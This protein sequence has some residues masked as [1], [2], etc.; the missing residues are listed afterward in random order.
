MS[1]SDDDLKR[2]KEDHDCKDREGKKGCAIC[3]LLARLEASE[4]LNEGFLANLATIKLD[5]LL[6]EWRKSR[7]E[8]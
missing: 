2:L 6:N 4:E 3:C 8:K 5:D 1:F 7:G